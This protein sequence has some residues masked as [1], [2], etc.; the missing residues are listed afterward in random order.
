MIHGSFSG[1]SQALQKE[2][3]ICRPMVQA[4]VLAQNFAFITFCGVMGGGAGWGGEEG[5]RSGRLGQISLPHPLKK[6]KKDFQ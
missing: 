6:K 2:R 5:V 3:L 1:C 4:M